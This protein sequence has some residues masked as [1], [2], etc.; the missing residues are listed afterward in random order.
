LIYHD[1][2]TA[3]KIYGENA[4]QADLYVED[5]EIVKFSD[6]KLNHY[7]YILD[8][9][10]GIIILQILYSET[11]QEPYYVLRMD[12][13]GPYRGGIAMD[14]YDGITIVA[15]YLVGSHYATYELVVDLKE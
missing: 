8:Q 5:F 4:Q 1:T 7:L 11:D 15:G 2:I 14:T 3:A 6:S 13:I 9:T 10:R 12:S